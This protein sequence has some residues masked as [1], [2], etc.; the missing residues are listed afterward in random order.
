MRDLHNYSGGRIAV[1]VV[2]SKTDAMSFAASFVDSEPA[3]GSGRW[4]TG[5]AYRSGRLVCGCVQVAIRFD[6]RL[7]LTRRERRMIRVRFCEPFDDDLRAELTELARRRGAASER[8]A[9]RIAPIELVIDGPA[10]ERERMTGR[11]RPPHRRHGRLREIEFGL[12][13]G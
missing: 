5:R 12:R 7:G 13:T 10:D 2:G 9:G 1:V 8:A 11:L 4:Q 6:D 3:P